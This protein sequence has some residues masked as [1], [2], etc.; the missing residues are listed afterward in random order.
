MTPGGRGQRE[1]S[2]ATPGRQDR[3]LHRRHPDPEGGDVK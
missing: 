3:G 1:R 2:S